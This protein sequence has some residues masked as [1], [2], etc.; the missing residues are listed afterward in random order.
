LT[1]EPSSLLHQKLNTTHIITVRPNLMWILTI[2]LCFNTY[3]SAQLRI[4]GCDSAQQEVVKRGIL[5]AQ[6]IVR[7]VVNARDGIYGNDLTPEI[8]H[9]AERQYFGELT[10]L[11]S[12]YLTGECVSAMLRHRD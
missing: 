12:D 10:E 11:Q 9:D 1:A 6:E 5:E 2:V 4:T 7:I 8:L 3:I